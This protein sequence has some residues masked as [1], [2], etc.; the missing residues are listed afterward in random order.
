MSAARAAA[1]P[2]ELRT[3]LANLTTAEVADDQQW[4]LALLRSHGTATV[5][6]LW[7]ML[8]SEPDVLDAYQTV[9]CRLTAGGRDHLG[10][11]P[12]GYFYRAAVNAGIEVLRRRKFDLAQRPAL[13]EV[14]SRREHVQQRESDAAS[15]H[16][17][18]RTLERMRRAILE[19][20]PY[21]RDVIVLHDL[22]ELPYAKV[23][24]ILGITMGSARVYRREA[25]V[26][27]A[28]VIGQEN[29]P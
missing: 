6:M 22:A 11:N 13:A 8:G 5:G 14:R 15:V 29:Q 20:P 21:L 4:I 2:S 16:D 26:R 3:L 1:L 18:R 17:R 19:L 7:R 25:V 23:A 27:L 28:D 24:G 9:V 10:R 12:G